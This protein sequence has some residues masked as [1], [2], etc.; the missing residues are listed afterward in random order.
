MILEG[1]NSSTEIDW[2]NGDRTYKGTLVISKYIPL[3]SHSTKNEAA[4]LDPQGLTARELN[5][6]EFAASKQIQA[7]AKD[8]N[9]SVRVVFSR[10]VNNNSYNSKNLRNTQVEMG[11]NYGNESARKEIE[12]LNKKFSTIQI[13]AIKDFS[14]EPDSS[15]VF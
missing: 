2:E 15:I 13:R 9:I 12:D 7:I 5:N 14:E 10:Y 1:K 4:S 6:E 3:D 8:Y 11:S